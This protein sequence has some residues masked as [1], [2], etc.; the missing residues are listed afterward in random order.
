MGIEDR[1]WLKRDREHKTRTAQNAQDHNTKLRKGGRSA[2][3]SAAE[4][5]QQP[6]KSRSTV[7]W[8]TIG[9]CI[10]GYLSYRFFFN[11]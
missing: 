5:R 9:L 8:W 7:I 11:P 2:R 6:A 1:D 10:S 3:L 4:R